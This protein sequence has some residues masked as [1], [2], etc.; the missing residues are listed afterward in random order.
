MS[1]RSLAALIRA[2]QQQEHEQSQEWKKGHGYHL[3]AHV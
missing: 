1:Q 3:A 2:K